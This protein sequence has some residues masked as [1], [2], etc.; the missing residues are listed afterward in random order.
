MTATATWAPVRTL[1]LVWLFI[2]IALARF[3]LLIGELP[4]PQMIMVGMVGVLGFLIAR[5]EAIGRPFME[6]DVRWLIAFHITRLVGFYFLALYRQGRLPY[7]FAVKGGIGDIVVAVLAIAVLLIPR[8]AGFRPTVLQVWNVI[9]FA[10][11]LFVLA[12]AIRL[13]I[14]DIHSMDELR[15]LPMS[16]LPTFLV[17]IVIVTHGVIGIRIHR[18]QI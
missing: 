18:R 7:D 12:T 10:D 1:A 8:S 13:T 5:T 4:I 14:G 3:G 9:G 11:I 2:V 15:R 17:P 6:C 16:L